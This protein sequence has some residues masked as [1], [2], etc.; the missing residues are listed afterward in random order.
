[1]CAKSCRTQDLS[2]RTSSPQLLIAEKKALCHTFVLLFLRQ[3]VSKKKHL[4]SAYHLKELNHHQMYFSLFQCFYSYGEVEC[5]LLHISVQSSSLPLSPDW[6]LLSNTS[7]LSNYTA[8]KHLCSSMI[9]VCVDLWI[10][11]KSWHIYLKN[12]SFPV[13]CLNCTYNKEVF[14]SQLCWIAC[15]F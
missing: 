3:D 11:G 10:P 9:G 14:F 4:T 1:M 13:C 15:I 8:Q 7:Q 2:E 12:C 6:Y 5:L